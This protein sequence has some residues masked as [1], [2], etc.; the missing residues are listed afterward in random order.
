MFTEPP[1]DDMECSERL[2]GT[3][4]MA[5]REGVLGLFS[6]HPAQICRS[7]VLTEKCSAVAAGATLETGVLRIPG[8]FYKIKH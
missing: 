6:N 7:V 1:N 8:S 4:G 2:C 3:F 5:K